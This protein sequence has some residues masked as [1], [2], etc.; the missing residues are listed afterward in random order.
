L[1][2]D[3]LTEIGGGNAV[4]IIPVHAELTTQEAA[5]ILNVSHP[6]FVQLLERG[7]IPFHKSAR[8]A[9]SATRT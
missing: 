2:I 5:D 4:S 8:T 9:A 6:F 1:L 7:E 3:V